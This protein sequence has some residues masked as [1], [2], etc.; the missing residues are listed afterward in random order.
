M[1]YWVK[2]L[3]DA[4]HIVT[5]GG[6]EPGTKEKVACIY[7]MVGD[8]QQAKLKA[9]IALANRE[10]G[11][12]FGYNSGPNGNWTF[13]YSVHEPRFECEGIGFINHHSVKCVEDLGRTPKILSIGSKTKKGGTKMPLYINNT[14]TNAPAKSMAGTRKSAPTPTA[15][16]GMVAIA[17]MGA[18]E[19]FRFE[20]QKKAE[21]T[22]LYIRTNSKEPKGINLQN[23]K[24]VT[25]SPSEYG[26]IMNLEIIQ[27]K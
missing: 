25:F 22:G 14:P 7:E 8:E 17:K 2:I 21:N 12:A 23:G 9:H 24:I 4:T 6:Y 3:G 18:L 26:T 20:S 10:Y 27:A 1:R 16:K 5:I 15:P 13:C 19:G 11:K